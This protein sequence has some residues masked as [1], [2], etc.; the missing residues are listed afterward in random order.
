[1]SDDSP[2]HRVISI[3]DIH[4][5]ESL[6]DNA[7]RLGC[8]VEALTALIDAHKEWERERTKDERRR[9]KA[10]T[11]TMS[12]S[13][14]AKLGEQMQTALA[15]HGLGLDDGDPS[16]GGP[17]M[18]AMVLMAALKAQLAGVTLSDWMGV[19]TWCWEVSIAAAE[20]DHEQDAP[21]TGGSE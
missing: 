11:V 15:E 10:M 12:P 2:K 1:M 3:Q 18:T 17:R 4:M 14:A 5:D 19:C 6:K 13:E 7:A 21:S 8:P 16:V 20:R 9:V